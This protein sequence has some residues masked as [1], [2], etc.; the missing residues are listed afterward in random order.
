MSGKAGLAG[1]PGPG[2]DTGIDFAA[3]GGA[4]AGPA[5][6][7]EKSGQAAGRA[8][9]TAGGGAAGIRRLALAALAGPGAGGD[10]RAV[11]GH[12]GQTG[13]GSPAGAGASGLRVHRGAARPAG[14]SGPAPDCPGAVPGGAPGGG[15]RTGG[16]RRPARRTAPGVRCPRRGGEP[17]PA[18]GRGPPLR[19][20]RRRRTDGVPALWGRARP[21]RFYADPGGAGAPGGL[22]PAAHTGRA[23]GNGASELRTAGCD[24]L[25]WDLTDRLKL[26]IILDNAK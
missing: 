4:R 18:P 1:A 17:E 5:P 14:H 25:F 13:A 15:H 11:P 26:H 9:D 12:G 24:F 16:R 23:V 8:G 2:G 6:A 7:P 20:G 21:G 22:R 10:R 3:G 19:R